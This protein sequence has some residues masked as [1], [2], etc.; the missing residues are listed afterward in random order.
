MTERKSFINAIATAVPEH[1]IH[2]D[3][4]AWAEQQLEERARPAFRRMAF[5]SGIEHRWSVLPPTVEGGSPVAPGGYYF[6]AVPPTSQRM[7]TYAAEAPAL[8]LRAIAKLGRLRDVTHLVVASCTGFMAP[9]IDQVIAAE[10]ELDPGI[11]RTL[12]GFMGCY[13]AV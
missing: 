3:F 6:G 11:E 8:A 9:G 5:R 12:V 4:I 10:L 13:A 2:A 7:E 1:D